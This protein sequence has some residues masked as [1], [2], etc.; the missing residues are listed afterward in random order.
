MSR[1]SS[2]RCILCLAL[3]AAHPSTL[4]AAQRPVIELTA[5]AVEAAWR[6]GSS[7]PLLALFWNSGVGGLGTAVSWSELVPDLYT[8]P[9][10]ARELGEISQLSYEKRVNFSSSI[11]QLAR[12]EALMP[13]STARHKSTGCVKVTVGVVDCQYDSYHSRQKPDVERARINQLCFRHLGLAANYSDSFSK[14]PRLL[15]FRPPAGKAP[16]RLIEYHGDQSLADIQE[17]VR[18]LDPV[19]QPTV[20]HFALP[21]KGSR[22]KHQSGQQFVQSLLATAQAR[23]PSMPVFVLTDDQSDSS[24]SAAYTRRNFETLALEHNDRFTFG[25]VHCNAGAGTRRCPG[26]PTTVH[27]AIG[28]NDQMG[29]GKASWMHVRSIPG[30]IIISADGSIIPAQK[31]SAG[32]CLELPLLEDMIREDGFSLLTVIDLATQA[33]FIHSVRRAGKKLALVAVNKAVAQAISTG[34][35]PETEK[36]RRQT[37]DILQII[38]KPQL[39]VNVGQHGGQMG[40]GGTS[41]AFQ[42]YHGKVQQL[43]QNRPAGSAGIVFVAID[44]TEPLGRSR[45]DGYVLMVADAFHFGTFGSR[46]SSYGFDPIDQSA[47]QTIEQFVDTSLLGLINVIHLDQSSCQYLLSFC[48]DIGHTAYNAQAGHDNMRWFVREGWNSSSY[49]FVYKR[50]GDN[51]PEWWDDQWAE[52]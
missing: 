52:R 43:A 32:R 7:S 34:I 22:K 37:R 25:S 39:S 44:I 17:F 50:D 23:Q 2:E 26:L 27:G 14:L 49:S 40:D 29:H 36:E 45:A 8:W 28:Y 6:G 24:E 31:P 21:S 42:N 38:V 13:C 9:K 15:Y 1:I 5:T 16:R 46:L 48:A 19:L 3:A 18:R 47:G 4:A 20:S 10:S 11:G 33:H 41:L 30:V 12:D 35:R 51:W